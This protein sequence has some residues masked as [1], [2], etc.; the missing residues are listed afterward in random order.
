MGTANKIPQVTFMHI[1]EKLEGEEEVDTKVSHMMVKGHGRGN[2]SYVLS[3]DYV[4]GKIVGIF[5]S[6]ISCNP[7]TSLRHVSYH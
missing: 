7:Q 1:Q 4:P 6:V 5:T 2:N 3:T